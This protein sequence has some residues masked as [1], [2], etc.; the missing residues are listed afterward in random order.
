MR[1]NTSIVTNNMN[2]DLSFMNEFIKSNGNNYDI[3]YECSKVIYVS[4]DYMDGENEA[5]AMIPARIPTCFQ[6]I[7]LLH[8]EIIGGD[9]RVEDKKWDDI[10]QIISDWTLYTFMEDVCGM[11]SEEMVWEYLQSDSCNT[12]ILQDSQE[13]SITNSRVREG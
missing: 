3:A 4:C 11:D 8:E 7:K 10:G 1:N 6:E 2:I 12:W 13:R 5:D 9:Y